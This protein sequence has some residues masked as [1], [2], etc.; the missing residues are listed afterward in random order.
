[1]TQ[2]LSTL[3]EV[4]IVVKWNVLGE[5]GQDTGLCHRFDLGLPSLDLS[6]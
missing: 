6:F 5:G 3:P 4:G 2:V 1:M